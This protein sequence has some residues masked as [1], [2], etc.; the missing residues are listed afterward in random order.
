MD[1]RVKFSMFGAGLVLILIAVWFASWLVARLSPDYMFA[2]MT[3][4]IVIG[5]GGVGLCLHATLDGLP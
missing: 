1:K 3:T 5:V 2:A 4:G